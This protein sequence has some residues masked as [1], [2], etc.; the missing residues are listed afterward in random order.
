MHARMIAEEAEDASYWRSIP[1]P[2]PRSNALEGESLEELLVKIKDAIDRCLEV[3]SPRELASA[4]FT[5]ILRQSYAPPAAE[6][7]V[8]RPMWRRAS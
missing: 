2:A 4:G 1:A 7:E 8:V 6:E 3:G 5:K